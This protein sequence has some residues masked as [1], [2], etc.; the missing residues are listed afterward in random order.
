MRP[1]EAFRKDPEEE[2]F[3][4]ELNDALQS[5]EE[6]RYRDLPERYATLH[7][8]GVPRTGTTL[9]TQLVA[10]HLDVGYIN[11]LIAAF[12]K[13]PTAGI[14]LSRKLLPDGRPR[15]FA[16]TFGLTSNV[17]EPHEF[18]YFWRWLLGY[19]DLSDLGEEHAETIDWSRVGRVLINMTWAFQRPIVFKSF[20][21]GMH[22]RQIQSLLP[23]TCFLR[24]R[25]DPLET[26]LS[27]LRMR[28]ELLG[29][30]GAWASMKPREYAWLR[31]E[32]IPVQLAGQVLYLERML[33]GQ[34]ASVDGR[35]VV[36][37]SYEMLCEDPNRVIEQ[38]GELLQRNESG[39]SR[40]SISTGAFK[41]SRPSRSAPQELVKAIRE[42]FIQ[43]EE[44]S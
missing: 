17:Q 9:A 28:E 29:S 16:S 8:I 38:I 35:N 32:S 42:A 11:R 18:G 40:T 43:L 36:E 37:S 19:E 4:T 10:A 13:A 1:P 6:A 22:I 2:R 26:A 12:W 27:L 33:D 31:H 21:L 20:W 41:V 39:V 14:R 34:V 30:A 3:L 15:A 5:L 7:V 44:R 24:I 25:R 23:R